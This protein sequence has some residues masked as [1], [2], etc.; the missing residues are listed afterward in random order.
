MVQQATEHRR[1]EYIWK[2]IYRDV[3]SG[4]A[5]RIATV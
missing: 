1:N 5:G 2:R 4:G 3:N